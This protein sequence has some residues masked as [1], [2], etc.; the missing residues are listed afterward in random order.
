M[1]KQV[2]KREWGEVQYRRCGRGTEG[3][4]RASEMMPKCEIAVMGVGQSKSGLGVVDV[5]RV[6]K[7]VQSRYRIGGM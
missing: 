5:S 6:E 4:V 7:A 2:Q 1:C 3:Y